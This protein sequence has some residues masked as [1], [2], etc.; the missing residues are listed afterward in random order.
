[1]RLQTSN[2][3][4]MV[5][6]AH[7]GYNAE[8]A[9]NNAFQS[10]KAANKLKAPNE[11][12]RHEFDRF[13]FKLRKAG[14]V[15]EVWDDNATVAKPDAIF[16]NNWL[17]LHQ[18]RSI[19][20]YPMFAP[21]RRKERDTR[22]IKWLR[23][24]YEFD[25][26]VDFTAME[27]ENLFL[28]GTGSLVLDRTNKVAYACLS[29]RT[30]AVLM[31]R[32]CTQFGY[33]K[34]LFRAV[35]QNG[36]DIYHTNVMMAMGDD[37]VVICKDSIVNK[38][39]WTALEKQFKSNKKDIITISWS[40]MSEYAGNMLLLRNAEEKNILVMSTRAH[41]SLKPRQVKQIKK[42]AEILHSEV[43]TIEN[44]GGGSVRCMMA[45]LFLEPKFY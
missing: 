16:P 22:L 41:K 44:L 6:P 26:V 23:Q 39:E 21:S 45:E 30:D 9:E 12:A 36:H 5:R 25:K 29:P 19:G 1:M 14:I 4:L 33:K 32:F 31:D 18:D 3:I 7:F 27:K 42:Y 15:V 20:L 11:K 28:E 13:V 17:S 24:S 43:N 38:Q 2:R 37:F 8:T 34:I 35:D 40:Q 10:K